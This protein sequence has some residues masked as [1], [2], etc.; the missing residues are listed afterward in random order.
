MIFPRFSTEVLV[1]VACM[2]S[3]GEYRRSPDCISSCV[4]T[5]AV[6][7]R[8]SADMDSVCA[9]SAQSTV[10]IAFQACKQWQPATF[11]IVRER[12]ATVAA[13]AQIPGQY[14]ASCSITGPFAF[15]FGAFGLVFLQASVSYFCAR[16]EL[17]EFRSLFAQR[18]IV[19][20]RFLH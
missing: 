3:G 15:V 10:F 13:P 1:Y 16:R 4:Q 19:S 17:R 2:L 20:L 18:C 8:F 9:S 11:K 7:E 12:S 5:F 6:C 14:L